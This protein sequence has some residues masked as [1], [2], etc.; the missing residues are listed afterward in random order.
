MSSR[1]TAKPRR[2]KVS[3]ASRLRPFWILI[4][5]VLMAAVAVGYFFATWPAL[6]PHGVEVSG[7]RVV[8]TSQIVAKAALAPNRNIWL[9]STR[10]MAARIEAIPYVDTAYVHRRPPSTVTIG[11]TEREPSA[12]VNANGENVV[13]DRDLR[14]LQN[15]DNNVK[16]LPLFKVD[17]INESLQPGTFLNDGVLHRLQNDNE[18]LISAHVT[19][20]ELEFDKYGELVVTLHSGVRLL[21][22]DDEDLQKKIPL[23]GPILS[24]LQRAGRPIAAI[25]LRAPNTPIVRYKK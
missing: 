15:A 5:L 13:V 19:P 7:N 10:A 9:Q 6:R 4:A 18:M 3:A 23:I 16:Q 20:D 11:V 8:P 14:V 1:P 22:G 21:L 12:I 24:Q 25:D 2:R 17:H